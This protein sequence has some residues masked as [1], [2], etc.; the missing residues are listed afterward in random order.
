M[1]VPQRVGRPLFTLKPL[2]SVDIDAVVKLHRSAMG[3]SFNSRLGAKHLAYLY[4][5]IQQDETCLGTVAVTDEKV[6][7][8]V[9]AVLTPQYFK[10]K[11]FSSM[12]FQRWISLAGRLV[13]QPS[14]WFELW[15]G[16]A[17]DH[18]VIYKNMEVKPTLI[19][20]AV[21]ASAR[22]AGVGRALVQSVD[23][24]F[25]QLA[26]P[27]YHLD[28]RADNST[29]RAFYHRLGFVEHERRGRDLILVKEL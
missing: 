15:Q 26:Q 1:A 12:S 2:S 7:G 9:S 22:Q 5:Q 27:F 4:S 3:Y 10:E 23:D 18:P 28:T 20:I 8:V 25:R 19:A 29:A 17:L 13:I 6:I 16:R 11:V 14:L 24:F 21:D